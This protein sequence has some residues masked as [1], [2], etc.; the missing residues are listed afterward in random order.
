MAAASHSLPRLPCPPQYLFLAWAWG[1]TAIA[2]VLHH[3]SSAAVFR[4]LAAGCIDA[5]L[6]PPSVRSRDHASDGAAHGAASA[7]SAPDPRGERGASA[8][9]SP[10]VDTLACPALDYSESKASKR[11]FSTRSSSSARGAA[12]TLQAAGS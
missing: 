5:P 11:S 1:V 12:H 3:A 10:A 8:V 2:F 4:A 6:L 7:D 9:V